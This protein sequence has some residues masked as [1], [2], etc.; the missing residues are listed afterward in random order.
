MN[1]TLETSNSI[2][3]ANE[4][5]VFFQSTIG[6]I[7]DFSINTGIK[8][9][10]PDSIEDEV[11]NIKDTLISEGFPQGI[12][13]FVNNVINFGKNA[14][15]IITGQFEN[16]SQVGKSI[17]KGNLMNNLSLAIDEAL[18][19]INSKK[20]LSEDIINSISKGKSEILN[21]VL[22]NIKDELNTQDKNIE[23]LNSY[24]NS[25]KL[26]Y[27]N[28]NIDGMERYIKKIDKMLSKTLPIENLFQEARTIENLHELIKNNGNNFELSEEELK[29]AE[30]I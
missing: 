20:T 28:R 19:K 14:L 12:K 22:S 16:I 25:W 27:E 15:G 8:A 2:D 18:N 13:N 7:I 30:V 1:N 23:N 6:K 10:L 4:Q 26:E 11:I 9:L 29:L 17:E 5:E 3:I 21:N 24:V